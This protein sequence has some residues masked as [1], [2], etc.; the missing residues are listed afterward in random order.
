MLQ[1]Y[2]D[3]ADAQQVLFTGLSTTIS[4][5][6]TKSK[7]PFEDQFPLIPCAKGPR[8]EFTPDSPDLA[9]T[10]VSLSTFRARSSTCSNLPAPD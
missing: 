7:P 9:G 5:V 3:S 1:C 10:Q 2:V 4:I 6:P 8:V